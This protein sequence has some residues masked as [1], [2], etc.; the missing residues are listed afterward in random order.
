MHHPLACSSPTKTSD[1]LC[2]WN[3]SYFG[4]P[5]LATWPSLLTL[6][7]LGGGAKSAPLLREFSRYLK[8]HEVIATPI[9][10]AITNFQDLFVHQCCT[11]VQNKSEIHRIFFLRI[12]RKCDVTTSDFW[13]KTRSV[14]TVVEATVLNWFL[15]SVLQMIEIVRFYKMAI[16]VFKKFRFC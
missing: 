7:P 12:W 11:Y 14:Q 5:E 15:I 2:Y 9:G 1:W 13:T 6:A 16:S 4:Y 8:K 3:L 10:V